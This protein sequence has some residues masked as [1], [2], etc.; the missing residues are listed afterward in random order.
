MQNLLRRLAPNTFEDII[1]LVALYRPG[2][3]ESGMT[4]DFVIRKRNPKRVKYPH[5]SLEP[6]LKDTLGVIVYQEQVMQISRVIGGFTMPEAD[7]LRKAMGKKLTD[8]MAAMKE[9]FIKGAAAQNIDTEMAKELY[10]QMEKF[11]EYGFNKSHS[12]AYAVVTY[13]TAW[14]K[15]RYCTEYMTALLS[16][17]PDNVTLLLNDCKRHSI[18]VLPP[19]INSS[20]Y[21]FTIEENKIRFGF[22]AIKGLGEKAIENI[23]IAR[24]DGDFTSLN[25]FFEKIDT[26]AVNRGVIESLIKAGAFDELNPDRARLMGSV[27][28]LMDAGRRSRAD[29][30]SGQGNLFGSGVAVP[31]SPFELMDIPEWTDAERLEHEKEVLGYYLSGHPLS[32]YEKDIEYYSTNSI[33][34]LAGN[35]PKS[36]KVTIA[37]LVRDFEVR[38]SKGGKRYGTGK[39][40]DMG[41]I[42]ELLVFEKKL[43]ELERALKSGVPLLVGGKIETEEIDGDDPN[44]NGKSMPTKMIV[45]SARALTAA[46]A[47]AISSI[48]IEIDPIGIDDRLLE[49]MK[50][51]LEKYRGSCPVYFHVNGDER[52]VRAGDYFNINPSDGLIHELSLIVGKDSVRCSMEY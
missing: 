7:K 19:S 2:P 6:V 15:A 28:L 20:F 52:G 21:D 50:S 1:A 3:L 38:V 11:G 34:G 17:A 10:E 24:E 31:E 27:E 32:K 48:H 33:D 43:D 37:G 47:D 35:I 49:S 41:G 25:D 44:S 9:K 42:I 14:L 51:T 40:E 30:A 8:I 18:P 39:L 12:A 36:G 22:S 4:D 26:F 23:I 45:Q 16:T 13:Q 46:R 29:K 5:P